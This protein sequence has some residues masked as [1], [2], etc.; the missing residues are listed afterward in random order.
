MNGSNTVYRMN[1]YFK[2]G[3]IK[4]T[5][6]SNIDKGS[7]ILFLDVKFFNRFSSVNR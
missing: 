5:K 2:R 3:R 7:I 6:D 1:R 4:E